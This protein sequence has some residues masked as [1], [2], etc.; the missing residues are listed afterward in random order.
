MPVQ[1]RSGNRRL[2]RAAT[3]PSSTSGRARSSATGTRAPPPR[4]RAWTWRRRTSAPSG[5]PSSAGA[6]SEAARFGEE[7]LARRPSATRA[8]DVACAQARAGDSR[9]AIAL[10][11]RAR[12]LGYSDR[13][14]AATDPD[15]ASLAGEPAFQQ[16][17]A[18]LGKS[19]AS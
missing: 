18:S 8:Y 16:W 5:W 1:S 13:E 10:L 7:S 15:L 9:R 4:P 19:A 3:P 6:Y 12:D 11:E 14:A 17:L 2:A